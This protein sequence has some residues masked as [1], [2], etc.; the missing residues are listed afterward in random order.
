MAENSGRK[1][2]VRG[3]PSPEKVRQAAA[4]SA[5]P[6]GKNSG[7]A[8]LLGNKPLSAGVGVSIALVTT[9]IV[10]SL[11]TSGKRDA[12]SPDDDV[13]GAAAAES[14]P[15]NRKRREANA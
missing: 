14:R 13:A 6:P 7:W 10:W 9:G 2:S 3:V 1:R 15:T 4:E 12:R 5:A 8:K 11:A